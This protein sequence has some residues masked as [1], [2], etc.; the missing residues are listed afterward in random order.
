MI[1]LTYQIY[2]H[3]YN[4]WYSA[5]SISASDLS[6]FIQYDGLLSIVILY[7]PASDKLVPLELG[8]GVRLEVWLG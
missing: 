5:K 4:K 7:Y 2:Y 1:T 6:S 3:L 8:Q